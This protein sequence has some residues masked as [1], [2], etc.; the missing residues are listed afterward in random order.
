M[1]AHEDGP[2]GDREIGEQT[3]VVGADADLAPGGVPELG[4]AHHE[5]GAD[6][7]LVVPDGLGATEGGFGAVLVARHRGAA[8]PGEAEHH[9]DEEQRGRERAD[10]EEPT[11]GGRHDGE[12]TVRRVASAVYGTKVPETRT[13]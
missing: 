12:P 9:G 4:L 11:A 6:L 8:D 1:R 10:G 7:E 3:H 2:V 13:W 5:R